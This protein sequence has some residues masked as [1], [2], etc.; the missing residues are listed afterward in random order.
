MLFLV[1][2][3]NTQ[4]GRTRLISAVCL[5]VSGSLHP[6]LSKKRAGGVPGSGATDHLSD[7]GWPTHDSRQVRETRGDFSHSVITE[8]DHEQTGIVNRRGS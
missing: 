3:P 5:L 1:G 6:L 8:T 4:R 2:L 7:E